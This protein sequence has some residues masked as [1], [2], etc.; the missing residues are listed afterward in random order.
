MPTCF[1][2]AADFRAWLAA[3]A[4][5][6]SELLVGFHKVG[7]G[8]P[9]LTWPQ[10]VDEA[11]CVGWIDGVRRRID[12]TAYSIR[13]TPRRRGS[14]WSAV[15]I[16]RIAVLDAE[17]RLQ[18]AGRAAFDARLAE[19]SRIFAYEQPAMP[20]LAPEAE[21]RFRADAAAWA[22]FNAQPASYRQRALWHVVSAKRE[23]TQASRLARLIAASAQGRRL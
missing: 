11:L 20:V 12:D 9:S 13:F 18:P 5:G 14:T 1:A 19:R 6:A 10:A 8:R 22:F 21:A 3:H 23:A 7:S 17:G 15:N 4:A 2:T 16:A